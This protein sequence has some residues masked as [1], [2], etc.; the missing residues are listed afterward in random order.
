[1]SIEEARSFAP[2]GRRRRSMKIDP[3]PSEGATNDDLARGVNQMHACLEDAKES[4]AAEKTVNAAFRKQVRA[5]IRE[6]RQAQKLLT[7]ALVSGPKK[8]PKVAAMSGWQLGWRTA[9][10]VGSG[11]G[12]AAALYRLWLAL[13]PSVGAALKAFLAAAAAGRI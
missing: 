3:V 2:R 7:G 13:E 11:V 10:G 9:V 5:D 1:M 6:I 12:G 8:P 4:A